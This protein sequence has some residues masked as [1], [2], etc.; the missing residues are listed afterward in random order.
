MG[1]SPEKLAR[2]NEALDAMRAVRNEYA[3]V[4]VVLDYVSLADIAN[5]QPDAED[6]TAGDVLNEEELNAVLWH[7]G[8]HVGGASQDVLPA[9][10]EFALADHERRNLDK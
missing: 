8:K 5:Y 7:V 10:V 3:D 6:Q 2:C 4:L 9:L 1:I